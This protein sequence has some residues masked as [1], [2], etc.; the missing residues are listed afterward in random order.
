M[1][2][3][4]DRL[5]AELRDLT[6][7][8]RG[9]YPNRPEDAFAHFRLSY[10]DIVSATMVQIVWGYLEYEKMMVTGMNMTRPMEKR[11]LTILQSP[12]IMN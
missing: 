10:P 8:V 12:F 1:M 9:Y 5:D 3:R 11:D 4:F 7:Q 2:E 6:D